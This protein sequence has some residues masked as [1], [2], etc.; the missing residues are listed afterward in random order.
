[1]HT[2]LLKDT[3]VLGYKLPKCGEEFF[4]CKFEKEFAQEI[5]T[6]IKKRMK[7]TTHAH[8]DL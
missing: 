7:Q 4:Y 5:I 8:V 1:M 3:P 2:D 6:R